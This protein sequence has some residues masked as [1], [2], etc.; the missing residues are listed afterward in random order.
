MTKLKILFSCV[1]IA[2]CASA[3][4]YSKLAIITTAKLSGHWPALK[5]FI[6]DA[7]LE[8]EWTACQYL[9]DDYPAFA[10]VTNSLVQNYGMSETALTNILSQAKD[11]AVPDAFLARFYE[12]SMRSSS[13]RAQWHGKRI[14]ESIDTN[15]FQKVTLYE[16]GTVF[17]DK[18]R[19]AAKIADDA[20][21]RRLKAMTNGVPARLAASRKKWLMDRTT[22]NEVTVTVTAGK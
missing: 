10:T 9:S 14:R 19:N 13:G 6:I 7:G 16:D 18:G 8:D 20:L 11:T 2:F 3:T 22:T 5:A 1:L 15:T 4:Q 17:C 12:T 21:D